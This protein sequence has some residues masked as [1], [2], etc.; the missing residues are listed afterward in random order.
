VAGN[1]SW[2]LSY[3]RFFAKDDQ[4]K[5]WWSS[6]IFDVV[7]AVALVGYPDEDEFV[8]DSGLPPGLRP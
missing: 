5:V 6:G 8:L 7:D 3:F 4:T 1:T 2:E